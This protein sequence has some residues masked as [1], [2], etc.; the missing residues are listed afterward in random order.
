MINVSTVQLKQMILK[1]H[2]ESKHEGGRY[3]CDKCEYIATYQGNLRR[4]IKNKHEEVSYPCNKCEFSTTSLSYLRVHIKNNHE[5][6]SYSRVLSR[7]DTGNCFKIG[8]CSKMKSRI[9]GGRK[10]GLQ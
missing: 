7:H 10:V 3:P 5:G 1:R 4:H 8:I 9:Y 2:F 6:V